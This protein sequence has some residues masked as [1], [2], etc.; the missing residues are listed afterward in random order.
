MKTTNQVTLY[1][2]MAEDMDVWLIKRKDKEFEMQIDDE[3]G[4]TIVEEDE[5]HPFAVE[6]FA[7]FCRNYLRTFENAN[8]RYQGGVAKC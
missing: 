6:A 5:I 8:K 1:D 4:R 2:L 7:R 3:N